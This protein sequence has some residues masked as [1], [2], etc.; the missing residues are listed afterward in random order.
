MPLRPLRRGSPLVTT[1]RSCQAGP[2][3]IFA[4]LLLADIQN[5]YSAVARKQVTFSGYRMCAAPVCASFNECVFSRGATVHTHS[6]EIV[7]A[8]SASIRR[9]ACGP[10]GELYTAR[11]PGC[12]RAIVGSGPPPSERCERSTA[13]RHCPAVGDTGCLRRHHC[14]CNFMIYYALVGETQQGMS[15]KPLR[16]L[17]GG[18][19]RSQAQGWPC[20]RTSHNFTRTS[21]SNFGSSHFG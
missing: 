12:G 9:C 18:R 20:Q 14:R 13:G 15:R 8:A 16:R 17:V 7:Q 21:R 5:G 11:T 1:H 10:A 6:S 19:E 2:S 3:D 4:R